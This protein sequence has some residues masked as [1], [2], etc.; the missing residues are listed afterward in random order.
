MELSFLLWVASLLPQSSGDSL[1]LATTVYLDVDS[2]ALLP[3]DPKEG[4]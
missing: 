1:C 3:P 2:A 4:P